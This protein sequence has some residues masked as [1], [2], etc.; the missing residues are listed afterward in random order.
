V[1]KFGGRDAENAFV[2][3]DLIS[4]L[5]L[6]IK[7]LF[8]G[9]V[10]FGVS[11]RVT[12]AGGVCGAMR[13]WIAPYL[14]KFEGR[15]AE[16][17]LVPWNPISNLVL[18]IKILFRDRFGFL[19]CYGSSRLPVE[20]AVQCEVALHPTCWNGWKEGQSGGSIFSRNWPGTDGPVAGA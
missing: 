5:V 17:A 6:D 20:C 2:P 4:N 12:V 8:R 3:W 15:G 19:E 9:G 14:L 7:I 1:L 13:R 18:D 11:W 10:V 16:N